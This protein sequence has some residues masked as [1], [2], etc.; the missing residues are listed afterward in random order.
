[1][2]TWYDVVEPHQD[3]K[4]GNF[5]ESIFAADL[6]NVCL[7]NAPI[8]Y[9]EP[10]LFFKKTYFTEGI[11]NLLNMVQNKL[12]NGKGSAVIEIKTP[13]GGGKT[14]ALISI[15]HYLKNGDKVKN[16]MPKGLNPIKAEVAVVVGTH[17]NPLEGNDRDGLNIRTLWGEV[18]YQLAGKNGYKEFEKNDK[19]K[20]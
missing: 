6:G 15:Y 8:E 10:A 13:F 18:A 7:G 11:K 5:D 1:M 4:E 17:L 2:T 20:I 3:I 19:D 12:T 16:Q 9:N 14:H